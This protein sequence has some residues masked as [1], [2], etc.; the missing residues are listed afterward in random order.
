MEAEKICSLCTYFKGLQKA[1]SCGMET[2]TLTAQ[3][4]CSPHSFYWDSIYISLP[5][6]CGLPFPT[7]SNSSHPLSS[8]S[9]FSDTMNISLIVQ[10]LFEF[11]FL[12][13]TKPYTFEPYNI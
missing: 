2:S 7:P 4:K 9:D 8:S 13:T 11:Q 3:W 10:A 5:I 1:E 6:V 12:W